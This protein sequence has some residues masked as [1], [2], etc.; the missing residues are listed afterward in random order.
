M[1]TD[2]LWI[3]KFFI[4]GISIHFIENENLLDILL[5]FFEFIFIEL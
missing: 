2:R 3:E 5:N 1:E 4:I